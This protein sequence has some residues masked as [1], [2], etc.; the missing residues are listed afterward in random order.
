MF[1]L[2]RVDQNLPGTLESCKRLALLI[3]GLWVGV[4][5]QKVLDHLV[6][7]QACNESLVLTVRKVL[8]AFQ[9]RYSV[10][11]KN[12]PKFFNA[13][14]SVKLEPGLLRKLD[15]LIGCEKGRS[16]ILGP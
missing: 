10:L 6:L 12:E 9:F 5:P 2:D 1:E 7:A 3:C 14:L 11:C 16:F 4:T 8:H 15:R 13:L